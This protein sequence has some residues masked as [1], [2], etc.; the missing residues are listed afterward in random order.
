MVCVFITYGRDRRVSCI[1][2][3]KRGEKGGFCCNT[4]CFVLSP[5]LSVPLVPVAARVAAGVDPRQREWVAADGLSCALPRVPH[6]SGKIH[7][8]PESLPTTHERCGKMG[9]LRER[10]VEPVDFLWVTKVMAYLQKGAMP[11]P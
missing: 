10:W 3:E 8:L 4:A 6:F 9:T 2:K 11:V 1:K 5:M 7:K